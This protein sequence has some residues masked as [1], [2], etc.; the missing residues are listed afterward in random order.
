MKSRFC[1]LNESPDANEG[2][3]MNSRYSTERSP[4]PSALLFEAKRKV[5]LPRVRIDAELP[6]ARAVTEAPKK[7]GC[8][9][10][11]H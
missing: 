3:L 4:T 1:D 6:S 9:V 2:T 10:K 8:S 7:V 11:E 5:V